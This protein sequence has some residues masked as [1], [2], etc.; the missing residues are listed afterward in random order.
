M[1]NSSAARLTFSNPPSV[2]NRPGWFH[3]AVLA[4]LTLLAAPAA[5]AGTVTQTANNGGNQSSYNQL[6]SWDSG[7]APTAGND[8]FTA[9]QMR[10]PVVSPGGAYLTG[11]QVFAGDSL[12]INGSANGFIQ[13]KANVTL[14]FINGTGLFLNGGGLFFSE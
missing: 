5:F 6:T 11:T 1:K 4:I 13:G 12:T 8:Y 7:V 3:L 14:S 10:S 9:F 2:L